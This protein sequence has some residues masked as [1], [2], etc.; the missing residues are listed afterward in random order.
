MS[1]FRVL[2]ALLISGGIAYGLYRAVDG[3]G[4]E[5]VV[6]A[7]RT[8]I[9]DPDRDADADDPDAMA[10]AEG[11][12][13]AEPGADAAQEEPMALAEDAADAEPGADTADEEPMALAEDAADTGGTQVARLTENP[14]DTDEGESA[15]DDVADDA[16]EVEA[17]GTQAAR[18]TGNPSGTDEGESAGD[19]DV[20]DGTGT[21]MEQ[22]ERLMEAPADAVDTARAVGASMAEAGASATEAVREAV[23]E[24]VEEAAT[25]PAAATETEIV[26]RLDSQAGTGDAQAAPLTENP[27]GT[28][29]GESAGDDPD[30]TAP[31]VEAAATQVARL[32]ENPSDT[33]E[34]E[35]TGDDEVAPGT[36]DAQAAR[37]TGNPSDTDEG[38]G[39]GDE[40]ADTFTARTEANIAAPARSATPAQP[41]APGADAEEIGDTE[42]AS[43][44]SVRL[45]AATGDSVDAL[46]IVMGG[47]TYREALATLI[48]AGWT[49]RADTG[50]ATREGEPN[51]AEAV[52]L[53]AGY[54][55]LEGCK[56]DER[57]ICRFEFVDGDRRIAA[58]LTA[59]AGT[60]PN[61]IDAFLMDIRAE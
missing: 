43:L 22:I 56:G 11:A 10:L 31:G 35:G 34:G 13:D 33:D 32:T 23:G 26:A 52:L 16:P 57:P 8:E 18:P 27:S 48:D 28:D 7:V 55:E 59:G 40:E 29:E 60:D 15:G 58:I 5:R 61:V 44:P 9:E 42:D 30:G 47:M 51:A 21:A 41:A 37:L 19:E 6:E 25:A 36:D 24:A 54:A 46:D 1:F 49:P 2:L 39:T 3:Q 4:V 53:E 14:S 38:E 50:R 17:D 45:A 20:A 12:E